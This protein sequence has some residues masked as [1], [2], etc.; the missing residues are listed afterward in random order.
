[1]GRRRPDGSPHHSPPSARCPARDRFRPQ[2][3]IRPEHTAVPLTRAP[4]GR[5]RAWRSPPWPQPGGTKPTR[6]A[7]TRSGT[8][9]SG[10][11]EPSASSI[12]LKQLPLVK[13]IAIRPTSPGTCMRLSRLS[14]IRRVA[15]AKGVRGGSR[16]LF[17]PN[18]C[19]Y[20]DATA[21]RIDAGVPNSQGYI[22]QTLFAAE[23]P[24]GRG[25]LTIDRNNPA[26]RIAAK[27]GP[28]YTGRPS[29]KMG[30][31]TGWT[32]GCVTATC[33]D[34]DQPGRSWSKLRCQY[35]VGLGVDDRDSGSP[36]FVDNGDGRYLLDGIIF[37]K[38]KDGSYGVYSPIF[39]IEQDLGTLTV[40]DPGSSPPPS[41]SPSPSPPPDGCTVNPI[42]PC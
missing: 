13:P 29:N 35:R 11:G 20:S 30:S 1:M 27:G 21:V 6:A 41:P 22:A 7:R 15:P 10:S 32:S 23:G 18:V 12:L 16:G 25:S 5:V 28:A 17:S 26:F 8:Q 38:A 42:Q 39:G 9:S 40:T 37:A 19:R 34:T 14:C 2:N 31:E 33:A 36:V 4:A 3:G 24:G